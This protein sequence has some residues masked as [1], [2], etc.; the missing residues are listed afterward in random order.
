MSA[1]EKRIFVAGHTG[2]VGHA[3]VRR[4]KH[5]GYAPPLLATRQELDLCEQGAVRQYL[6]DEKPDLVV[7][8]AAK[9]GGIHANRTYP[10]DFIHD[11]LAIALN[12]IHESYKLGVKRL[13]FL[14]STCI[15]PRLAPQ[16]IPEDALLSSALEPTNEAYALAKIA[17]LKLCQHYR[18]QYGVTY[19]SVMP[20]NMYGPNDNYDLANSHVLPA[21][22]RKFHDAK[23]EGLPSVT[24]WGSGKPRREFLHVDDCA[25]AVLH[26]LGVEDPPD[27]V[28]VGFGD[29]VTIAEL[30][31]TIRSVVGFE[32]SIE[33]DTSKPDGPPR[34]LAD[35]SRLRGL[36]WE[37]K[38]GLRQGL[39]QT[40]ASF[41][42]EIEAGELRER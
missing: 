22:L 12:L 30:A 2:M 31:E 39:E 8:A 32:G 17:G 28:N 26:L 25:D 38:I 42:A 3:L 10:A 40:Y 6:G 24:V 7:V 15:Y 18:A 19:H 20:T 1:A 37:P 16:P 5:Y 29:D 23:I 36:G 35:S 27:W 9:V 11:N 4:L 34:K 13:V 21:L 33:L 14:G 41:L